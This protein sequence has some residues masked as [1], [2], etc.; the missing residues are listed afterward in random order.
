MLGKSRV[1]RCDADILPIAVEVASLTL[2][3]ALQMVE[4]GLDQSY[5]GKYCI[6]NLPHGL[7]KIQW[8][9]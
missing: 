3:G 1:A 9:V 8:Q 6:I 5:Y 4:S 2:D 7:D